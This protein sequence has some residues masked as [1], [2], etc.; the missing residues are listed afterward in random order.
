MALCEAISVLQRK[1]NLHFRWDCQ[2]RVESL[3]RP[4]II[5][6]MAGANCEAVYLGVEALEMNALAYLKKTPHPQHYLDL[7]RDRVVPQ[8]IESP[9]SVYIN[10][11]LGLPIETQQIRDVTLSELEQLGKTAASRG[12]TITVFPQ[13]HVVYPGTKHYISGIKEKRFPADVS[14][15]FTDWEHR[16]MPVLKFLGHKFAHGTGGLCEGILVTEKLKS[17]RY[18]INNDAIPILSTYLD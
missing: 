7:L 11:Q 10:I 5:E 12:K 17:R 18:E 4:E 8:L 15:T 1:E 2:T 13:L 9:I 6:A 16:E 14:E 3:Q